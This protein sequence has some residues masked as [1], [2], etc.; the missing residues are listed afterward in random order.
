MDNILFL[1]G[2]GGNEKSFASV[3]PFFQTKYNCI[4]PALPREPET[5]WTLEDYV[6]LVFAEL[7]QRDI[8]HTHIIA[9]SFG[10]RV[11]VLL[12]NLQP[13]RFGRLVLA[14]PAG[15][16]PRLSFFRRLKIRLHKAGI[17]K[18]RGSTDYRG[19]TPAGKQTF[20][21][22]VN[23]D[24]SPEISRVRQPVLVIWGTKDD[25]IKKKCLKRWTNLNT[26]V[27]I[28]FYNKAGHFCFLDAPARFIVDAEEFL[29]A[30]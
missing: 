9:H 23:R 21:N 13:E 1:H 26:C 10:A 18:S 11:A 22:I 3:L 19:L 8:K 28:K 25:S 27:R 16:R 12:V 30:V 17:I 15:I 29:N 20:Q 7:D 4:C 5:P 14:G 24:L 6:R 2:W